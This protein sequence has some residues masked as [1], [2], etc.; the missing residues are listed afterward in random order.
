VNERL[1]E[2]L[3]QI[4]G[5]TIER[6]MTDR[7]APEYYGLIVKMPDGSPT[8]VW[9]LQDPEG[10]GPGHLDITPNATIAE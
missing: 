4:V 7:D 1:K 9:V 8:T 2:Y 5:G 10:N 3:N 6:I